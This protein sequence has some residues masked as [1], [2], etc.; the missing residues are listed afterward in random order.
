MGTVPPSPTS[1]IS[2]RELTAGGE[3]ADGEGTAGA[4]ISPISRGDLE[5]I[6]PTSAGLAPGGDI[7]P[8]S[9][10]RYTMAILSLE[11]GQG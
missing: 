1:S 9:L 7:Q 6:S 8:P 10:R 4:A 5:R 3:V 2:R 11:V